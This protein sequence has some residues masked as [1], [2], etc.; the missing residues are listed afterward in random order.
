[1]RAS[2]VSI[3]G[4][5]DRYGKVTDDQR[6]CD[7][8]PAGDGVPEEWDQVELMFQHAVLCPHCRRWVRRWQLRHRRFRHGDPGE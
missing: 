1:M 8:T 7:G 2:D 5:G 6:D 3:S 4:R